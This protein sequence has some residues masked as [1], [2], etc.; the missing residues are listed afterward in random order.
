MCKRKTL[1][2]RVPADLILK[3]RKA[4]GWPRVAGDSLATIKAM[5]ELYDITATR[6]GFYV[7][8]PRCPG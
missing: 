7:A 4:E 1:K 6:D 5:K 8:T 3:V 2:A